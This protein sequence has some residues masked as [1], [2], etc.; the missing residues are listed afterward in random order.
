MHFLIRGLAH[1]GTE[2]SL[3]LGHRALDVEVDHGLG[4]VGQSGGSRCTSKERSGE[5][6]P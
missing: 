6:D 2:M 4:N 1:V 3:R 5:E